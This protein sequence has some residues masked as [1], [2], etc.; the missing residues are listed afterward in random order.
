[1]RAIAVRPTLYLHLENAQVD[2][3]L[4]FRTAIAARN[5]PSIDAPGLIRPFPQQF[6]EI[7]IIHVINFT[8][9]MG[10]RRSS[11]RSGD[12]TAAPSEILKQLSNHADLIRHLEAVARRCW[13]T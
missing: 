2:T 4:Q 11:Y 13:K 6:C 8:I 12:I 9:W 5:S 7:F 10:W 3:N 1:M